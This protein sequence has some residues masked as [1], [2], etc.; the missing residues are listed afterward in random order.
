MQHEQGEH[1]AQLRRG[2]RD[3]GGT[4]AEGERAEQAHPHDVLVGVV[5]GLG[6]WCVER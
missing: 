1:L 6:F 5:D 4:A 2:R 3:Q